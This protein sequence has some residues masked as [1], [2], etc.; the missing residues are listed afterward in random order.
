MK[1][2]RLASGLA[3]GMCTL[4]PMASQAQGYA[5]GVGLSYEVLPLKLTND[6]T[7]QHFRAD[8]FRANVILPVLPTADSSGS[9][10]V[11]AS[12]EHLRFSG[13]RTGFPVNTV[14]GSTLR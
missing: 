1:I 5:E 3:L 12:L 9:V 8:V 13:N 7:P 4:L 10:L 14:T 11:G 6:D 2:I